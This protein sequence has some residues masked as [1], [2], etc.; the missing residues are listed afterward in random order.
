[1]IK[2]R[3]QY[4]SWNSTLPTSTSCRHKEFDPGHLLY[5]GPLTDHLIGTSA[6]VPKRP[7]VTY[8]GMGTVGPGPHELL[9][10]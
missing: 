6:H 9:R 7:M 1:M 8:T 4:L 10:H 3:G 2:R 5:G